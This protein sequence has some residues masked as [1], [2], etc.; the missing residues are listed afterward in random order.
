MNVY[1]LD[2]CVAQVLLAA[3]VKSAERELA[4]AKAMRL[5][6]T[7]RQL[8]YAEGVVWARKRTLDA[9]TASVQNA[10]TVKAAAA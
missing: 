9:L 2:P 3:T 8:A 5:T 10:A 6:A 1:D 4:A 7:G